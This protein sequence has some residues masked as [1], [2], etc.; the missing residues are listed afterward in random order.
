[1]SVPINNTHTD[2]FLWIFFFFL[3]EK[4][5]LINKSLRIQLFDS[6]SLRE[7]E[8]NEWKM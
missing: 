3:T 7:T 8:S 2:I 4:I 6:P 5:K 1:M